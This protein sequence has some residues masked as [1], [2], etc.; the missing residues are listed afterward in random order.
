M[1]QIIASMEEEYLAALDLGFTKYFAK[2]KKEKE[3]R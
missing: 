2:K 3:I 1:A